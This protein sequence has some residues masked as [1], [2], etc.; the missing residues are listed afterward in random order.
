MREVVQNA[1]FSDPNSNQSNTRVKTLKKKL[2]GCLFLNL[3]GFLSFA[4]KKC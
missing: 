2:A 3:L 1:A 4:R